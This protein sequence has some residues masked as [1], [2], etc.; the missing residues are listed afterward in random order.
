MASEWMTLSEAERLEGNEAIASTGKKL[1][2]AIV[3]GV[4]GP[5]VASA[6][7]YAKHAEKVGADA[8]IS[9]PP[10]ESSDAKTDLEYYKAVGGATQLPLFVQAV[11][12]MSVDLLIEMYKAIPTFRYAKDEAGNP[13]MS[14]E[15]L[16]RRSSGQLNI[17]SGSHGRDLID[18]MRR[19]FSGSMPAAPFADLYAQTWDLWQQGKHEEALAMHART[20][21]ILT[22]MLSH[23]PESVKYILYLRGVFK[24]YGLRTRQAPGFSSAAK[25]AA[26]GDQGE[27]YL[28]EGGKQALRETLDYL[29]PYLK[30]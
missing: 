25:V 23:G 15:P 9:L 16:R 13:L 24:T 2:P 18:E 10:S 4:Q 8:I 20:L 27:T 19:G 1:R 7:K 11:G 12:N 21:L 28:D 17:F 29:K 5:N 22:E 6:I 26:G 3:L 30:A 14:I